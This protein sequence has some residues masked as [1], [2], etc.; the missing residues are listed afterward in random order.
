MKNPLLNVWKRVN[1]DV[2]SKIVFRL[3]NVYVCGVFLLYRNFNPIIWDIIS[4]LHCHAHTYLHTFDGMSGGIEKLW[5]YGTRV[6]NWIFYVWSLEYIKHTTIMNFVIYARHKHITHIRTV[7]CTA[8][9]SWNRANYHRKISVF[10]GVD[11]QKNEQK[12]LTASGESTCWITWLIVEFVCVC[13]CMCDLFVNPIK[14]IQ[15]IFCI[16]KQ[17]QMEIG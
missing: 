13:I 10:R 7:N 1:V 14:L 9:L 4:W 12:I 17:S 16:A 15:P 5:N 6:A 2:N 11:Q 8:W 3:Y